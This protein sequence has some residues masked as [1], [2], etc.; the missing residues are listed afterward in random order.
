MFRHLEIR[1][2]LVI[3]ELKMIADQETQKKRIE[4]I[5]QSHKPTTI[6]IS[7]ELWKYLISQKTRPKE[8]FEDVIWK[9]IR[10]DEYNNYFGGRK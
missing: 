2:W 4:P 5:K 10:D 6:K 9:F 3:R 8:T 1:R 7:N